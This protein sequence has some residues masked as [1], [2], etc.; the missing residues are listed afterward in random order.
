MK[1]GT[2][3]KQ[4]KESHF[5]YKRN[6]CDFVICDG[7]SG[8]NKPKTPTRSKIKSDALNSVTW[9]TWPLVMSTKIKGRFKHF[10]QNKQQ[11]NKCIIAQSDNGTLIDWQHQNRKCIVEQSSNARPRKK[12]MKVTCREMLICFVSQYNGFSL[13]SPC[14]M[15]VK[16]Q[17]SSPSYRLANKNESLLK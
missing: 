10:G 9:R 17:K 4:K 7:S 12:E 1:L 13:H 3:S 16:K 11:E 2:Q 5:T 15:I 8:T 14:A 6:D